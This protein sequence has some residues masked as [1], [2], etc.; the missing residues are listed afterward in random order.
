MQAHD[1]FRPRMGLPFL[2]GAGPCHCPFCQE[3][4][5]VSAEGTLPTAQCPGIL[6]LFCLLSQGL[7]KLPSTS[8]RPKMRT[9]KVRVAVETGVQSSRLPMLCIRPFIKHVERLLH[10]WP[11]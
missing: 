5:N 9:P 8:L 11:S 4:W 3:P 2:L 7:W 6:H 10:P 1:L